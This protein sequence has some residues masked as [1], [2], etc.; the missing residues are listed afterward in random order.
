VLNRII[1]ATQFVTRR[2]LSI[3]ASLRSETD[4]KLIHRI[5]DLI[6][7]RDTTKL[8]STSTPVTRA[9]FRSPS[10]QAAAYSILSMTGSEKFHLSQRA[11]AEKETDDGLEK[12][13]LEK[14]DKSLEKLNTFVQSVKF[15]TQK[16]TGILFPRW[17][18]G[19]GSAVLRCVRF[20]EQGSLVRHDRHYGS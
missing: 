18:E 3:L 6:A 9:G 19:S 10:S 12:K 5:S 16:G 7:Y 2:K 1:H 8:P 11:L 4:E 13:R 20:P 17:T 14:L 15:A